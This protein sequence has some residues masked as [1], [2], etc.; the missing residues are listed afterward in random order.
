MPQA[1]PPPDLTADPR[2]QGLAQCVLFALNNYPVNQC[3][4]GGDNKMSTVKAWF[5]EAMA[6]AGFPVKDVDPPPAAPKR[7][8]K[9]T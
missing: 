4:M 1:K 2:V 7:G 9:P 6:A 5:S 3:V 8:R